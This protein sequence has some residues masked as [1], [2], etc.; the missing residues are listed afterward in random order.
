MFT[1]RGRERY[2]VISHFRTA[3]NGGRSTRVDLPRVPGTGL[4][5]QESPERD[6]ILNIHSEKVKAKMAARLL[7]LH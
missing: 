4:F 1:A 2:G 7:Y 5:F 6:E 3:V